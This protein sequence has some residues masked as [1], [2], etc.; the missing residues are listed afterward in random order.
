MVE[1]VRS[2]PGEERVEGFVQTITVKV[3]R[4]AAKACNE[5]P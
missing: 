4:N 3:R 5:T 1:G 2:R